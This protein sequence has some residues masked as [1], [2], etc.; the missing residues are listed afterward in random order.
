MKFHFSIRSK[1]LLFVL[2]PTLGL[3]LLSAYFSHKTLEKSFKEEISAL[4]TEILNVSAERVK[5]VLL[6]EIDK[7]HILVRN[8]VLQNYLDEAGKKYET[9]PAGSIQDYFS[10]RD[11]VWTS[12]LRSDLVD[13]VLTNLAAQQ[14]R[15]FQMYE[16]KR[17]GEIFITDSLGGLVASTDKTTDFYQGDEI[18]WKKNA[19]GPVKAFLGDIEFDESAGIHSVTVSLPIR[20][21]SDRKFI[22]VMKVILSVDELFRGSEFHVGKTGFIRVFNAMGQVVFDPDPSKIRQRVDSATVTLVKERPLPYLIRFV[23]GLDRFV[24]FFP[25]DLRQSLREGVFTE[26]W[27]CFMLEQELSEAFRPLWNTQRWQIIRLSILT[28]ILLL[29]TLILG[30]HMTRPLTQLTNHTTELARGNFRTRI[31]IDS[32]DEFEEL[33]EAFNQMAVRIE[34]YFRLT[35]ASERRYKALFESTKEGILVVESETGVIV[36]VNR[37]LLASLDRERDEMVGRKLSVFL[38]ECSADDKIMVNENILET[39]SEEIRE[40]ELISGKGTKIIFEAVPS[41]FELDGK[42]FVQYLFKNITEKKQL[43][44]V[45]S[46]LIRDVAHELR[47]PVAKLQISLDILLDELEK[48]VFGNEKINELSRIMR[49][50]ID[51]LS[52]SIE[53]ILDYSKLQ[54]G[55]VSLQ[56]EKLDIEA[57]LHEIVNDYKELA[58]EKGLRIQLSKEGDSALIEA[59]KR[60]LKMAVGNLISNAIKFTESGEVVVKALQVGRKVQ[61]WVQ[62]TGIGI[63][64]EHMSQVFDKFYQVSPSIPGCGIG[65]SICDEI[66]RLHGGRIWVESRGLGKGSVFKVEINK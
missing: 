66:I 18:W 34:R 44:E 45:R 23:E 37:A 4:F 56:R 29:C 3:T 41:A 50:G 9:L 39:R 65:L 28:I 17:Y 2:V 13:E 64:P 38:K 6:N 31:N 24:V 12:A 54:E 58:G 7:L 55:V 43:D 33:G 63:A 53:S 19:D 49:K 10:E 46:H 61:I 40:I 27:W 32:N 14:L 52:L 35:E 5:R 1:I 11:R 47:T 48:N 60:L 59:D 15:D 22:G 21:I 20:R 30:R 42:P 25:V 62:D 36:N 16:R 51:R 57:L 8:P 26:N